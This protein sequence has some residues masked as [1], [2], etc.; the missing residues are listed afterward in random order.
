MKT[1]RERIGAIRPVDRN[2]YLRAKKRWDNLA[3]PIGGLGKVEEEI[4]RI[5]AIKGDAH[6]ENFA[7][8]VFCADN[9]VVA[10][11]VSQ[12]GQD[13]TKNVADRFATGET[14]SCLMARRAGVKVYPLDVGVCGETRI[15]KAK[16]LLGTQN[17]VKAAAMGEEDFEAA[18]EAG[19]TLAKKAKACGGEV[20]L[21]GEMGI[22]N[23]T[24]AT[25]AGC[26]LLH[27]DPLDLT[28]R[29][30][31]L[32]DAGLQKK[33]SAIRR[34]LALHA[35]GRDALDL[36]RKVGSLDMAAMCGAITYGA[37]N[38]MPVILDGAITL[39]AAFA[40]VKTHSDVRDYLVPAHATTE[41]VSQ[42][43]L[44]C[45]GFAPVIEGNLHLGE[46]TG[47]LCLVPILQMGAE[48]FNEMISFKA[49]EIPAYKKK[50]EV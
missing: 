23:T 13:V 21:L 35:P 50:D 39:V 25:A 3:K 37:L 24:A 5:Y 1:S 12:T 46:G 45:L 15:P 44:S 9:G 17:M 33:I 14:V 11:G 28:G 43:I 32:S 40:M 8:L 34:A 22:G 27:R 6:L 2:R 49:A 4:A 20:L 41:K 48:V 16:T 31:G 29:G 10:E 7:L 19:Y 38:G 42:E 47:A 18:F 30:A 26:G 36:I